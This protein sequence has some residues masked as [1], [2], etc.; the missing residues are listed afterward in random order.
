MFW[1]KIML[2]KN[3]QVVKDA[4]I[5]AAG[6]GKRLMPYTRYTPKPLV[7]ING[8][9]MI[10]YILDALLNINIR[11]IYINTHYLSEEIE[12]YFLNKKLPNVYITR[13]KELLDT[14]GGIK[15]ALGKNNID[16]IFVINCDALVLHN[17]S[18]LLSELQNNFI[19]KKMDAMLALSKVSDAVGYSGNGDFYLGENRT[20]EIEEVNINKYVFMG[21][22]ILNPSALY[23]TEKKKFSLLE[24]WTRLIS[25]KKCFGKIYN[26]TWCHTGST[27]SLI[28]AEEYY[29]GLKS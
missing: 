24:T 23:L 11:N 9:P 21:I 16:P 28:Y 17:Y 14:G 3:D 6:L 25:D 10:E 8:R 5:L 1:W 19:L 26:E 18:Q 12:N 29:K 22:S 15:N 13:E 7:P 27:S 4:F 2:R 20:V